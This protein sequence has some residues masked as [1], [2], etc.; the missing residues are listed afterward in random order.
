MWRP[1]AAR[2][3]PRAARTRAAAAGRAP[4]RPPRRGRR[5]ARA[6]GP[7]AP[8][9]ALRVPPV[10][11]HPDPATGA[12]VVDFTNLNT[13]VSTRLADARRCSLCGNEIGYWAAILG[14]PRAAELMRYTD[15]PGC[16]DCLQAAVILCPHIAIER[17]RRARAD[18]P[19]AGIIPPGSHGDKPAP[20]ILG[21]TRR[22]RTLFLPEHRFSGYLPAP[23]RTIHTYTYDADGRINP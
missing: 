14:G 1:A 23:F 11:L 13:T 20:W 4:P 18:R 3:A 5:R 17:H 21:I 22:Y 19:R 12:P 6:P 8:G 16:V 15:P 7:R 2:R 10:N 9:R